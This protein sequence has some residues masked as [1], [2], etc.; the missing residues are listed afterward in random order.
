[1]QLAPEVTLWPGQEATLFE[2]VERPYVVGIVRG[3]AE[4][5]LPQ[6]AVIPEGVNL[7]LA[8]TSQAEQV[9][10]RCSLKLTQIV[11]V[12]FFQTLLAE[13]ST[14]QIPTVRTFRVDVDREIREGSALL[15]GCPPSRDGE[16]PVYVLLSPQVLP[17]GRAAAP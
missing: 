3:A 11:G 15:I 6:V 16:E 5:P 4:K 8:V 10:L 1:M 13:G 2:G 9:R 12:R 7:T 14:V 17:T